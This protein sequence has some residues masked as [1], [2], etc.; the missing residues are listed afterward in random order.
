MFKVFLHISYDTQRERLLRRL[1]RPDKQWKFNPDDIDERR[2]WPKYQE[3]FQAMLERCD[4]QEAPWYVV[5]ADSK[6]Y[7]NWAVGTAPARDPRRRSTRITRTLELDVERCA[8]D[9]VHPTDH[10]SGCDV[11][12]DRCALRIDD[13]QVRCG[14]A[15]RVGR[16]ARSAQPRRAAPLGPRGSRS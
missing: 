10:A 14:A 11:D 1:D 8:S 9:C 4:T 2:L 7:R 13:Q 15:D 16:Q 3:A 5:P 6:K 12:L